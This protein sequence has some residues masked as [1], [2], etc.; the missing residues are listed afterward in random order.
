MDAVHEMYLWHGW[1]PLSDE[2]AES[3]ASTTGSAETRWSNDRRLAMETA[4]SYAEGRNI[5]YLAVK[6]L[7]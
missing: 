4:K 7:V 3:R 1:W 5:S 6:S 2:D